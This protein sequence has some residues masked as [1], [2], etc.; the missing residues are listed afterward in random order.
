VFSTL[1]EDNCSLEAEMETHFA[2]AGRD[3]SSELRRRVELVRNA[4]LLQATLDAMPSAVVILNGNRQVVACNRAMVTLLGVEADELVGK[5]PGEILDCIHWKEGPD[6]CGTSKYCSTCG[7][8][9]AI[10]SSQRLQSQFS[11]ECRLTR[12]HCETSGAVELRVTATPVEV[13][14]EQFVVC[15]LD[16]ISRQKRLAVL[17]RMFFHD[18][19]NTAG[20]LQGYVG[21]LADEFPADKEDGRTLHSLVEL[22]EQ[23]IEEI[24]AQRDLTY[25][26]A[27][28]LE[29]DTETVEIKTLLEN[30]G[31]RYR[32]HP[33]AMN[34]RVELDTVSDGHLVTDLRL[35]A[36][37]L[38]NMVKNALEATDPGGAVRIGCRL[39]GREV[40]FRVHNASVMPERVQLQVFQRSFTTKQGPGRGLG[41]HSMKLIGE[42][43]LKGK[44]AFTSHESEG[45]TF[46]LTLPMVLL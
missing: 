15:A 3:T 24:Q 19:L 4:P 13:G 28:E 44:V 5:R 2:P 40:T 30:L 27:G 34:R 46:T 14:G 11:R 45:T 16:D 39:G 21:M 23:L 35:L 20:C 36:R 25:A 17:T 29:V 22:A 10:L 26:E 1:G 8:V 43:Y 6:G 12:D 33:V 31:A 7:A 32:R 42:R 18:V 9:E 38:G 41:T 37:V